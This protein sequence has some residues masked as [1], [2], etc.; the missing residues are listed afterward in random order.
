MKHFLKF[1]FLLFCS[2]NAGKLWSQELFVYTEPA[3]NMPAKSL[4]IRVSNWIMNEKAYRSLNYHLIP[5]LM[6]G[7]NKNLMI[8]AEGFFSNRNSRLQT[9]GG[10]LYAKYRF[11]T[12]DGMNTHFRMAAFGRLGVNNAD[13]HQEEIETNGH[14][15]GYELGWVGTQLLHKQAISASVSFEHALD[16]AKGNKFPASQKDK[17]IN[18]TLSTGRLILPKEYISY[19]QTNLNL[20]VEIL[21]QSIPGSGRMYVDIAPSVQLIFNSQARIDIGYRKPLYSNMVRTAPEGF[22]LRF[23]YLFFN[24]F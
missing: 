3:S 6:W 5:E 20:M 9:E 10:G 14:N 1:T 13:I 2:L 24:A 12:T 18:Y 8:H 11:F 16:N 7:V 4:G 23:E 19:E 22:L 15:S 21:G 17:A